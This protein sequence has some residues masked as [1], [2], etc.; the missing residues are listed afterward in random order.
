MLATDYDHAL[1]ASLSRFGVIVSEP[2]ART[3]RRA[4][5]TLRRWG[6]RECGDSYDAGS[7]YVSHAIERDEK[8]GHPYDVRHITDRRNNGATRT[9]RTRVPDLER[10]ALARVAE[11]CERLGF[12]FYH[13]TDPRGASLYVGP[14][15]LLPGPADAY[16]NRLTC[17]DMDA[18]QV[19]YFLN[20]A[21]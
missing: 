9:I 10:G 14:A 13:Q 3:L 8:T 6:E 15:D 1:A 4:E 20:R 19:R 5:K 11:V 17:C 12:V 18:R 2:D 7:Y 21:S 16:Y